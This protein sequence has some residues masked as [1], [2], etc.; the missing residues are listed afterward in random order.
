MLVVFPH[1]PLS[2]G[3]A[4]SRTV[5]L[6]TLKK[7]SFLAAMGVFSPSSSTSLLV[8]LLQSPSSVPA[9]KSC[10][11]R[12]TRVRLGVMRVINRR[13]E[14]HLPRCAG[15]PQ[16]RQQRRRRWGVG[17]PRG[18]AGRLIG[19]HDALLRRLQTC[20]SCGSGG[21]VERDPVSWPHA[22]LLPSLLRLAVAIVRGRKRSG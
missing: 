13:R 12:R 14:L 10:P 6:T 16:G 4:P 17:L 8:F 3:R 11:P 1:P 20:S 9:L 18:R 19:R 21:V 2:R 5:E 7:N 22:A 15:M